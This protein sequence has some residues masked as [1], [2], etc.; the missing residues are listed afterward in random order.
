MTTSSTQTPKQFS[1]KY[2]AT[3]AQEVKDIIRDAKTYYGVS[4]AQKIRE[5]LVT[6]TKES[7]A[8]N[9]HLGRPLY[10]YPEYEKKG[11]RR[12]LPHSHYSIL[13]LLNRRTV[14]IWHV[15]DNRRDWTT[16]FED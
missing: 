14:E 6:K 4:A 5:D 11:I 10:E 12:Y 9:P 2:L 1:V 16:L 8:N 7:L 15:W 3:A 13:Y